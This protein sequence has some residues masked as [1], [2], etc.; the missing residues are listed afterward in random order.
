MSEL[1]QPRQTEEAVGVSERSFGTWRGVAMHALAV[2]LLRLHTITTHDNASWFST[3]CVIDQLPCTCS[4]C[5]RWRQRCCASV[6]P[7]EIAAEQAAVGSA[8]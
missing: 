2:A 3:A 5:R 7:W 4:V 6:K 1:W 8:D